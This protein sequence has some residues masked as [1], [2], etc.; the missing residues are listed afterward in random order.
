MRARLALLLLP[1]ALGALA[2]RQAVV[3]MGDA[4]AASL[5]PPRARHAWEHEEP[6]SLVLGPGG[7]DGASGSDGFFVR[8][9]EVAVVRP[10]SPESRGSLLSPAERGKEAA[11]DASAPAP[12]VATILVPAAAVA[13]AMQRR[14]VGAVNAVSPEGAP[15]GAS[16]RGVSRYRTGLRDGDVV[17]SVAGTPTPNVGAMVSAAMAAAQGGAPRISGQIMREGARMNVVL[18]LPK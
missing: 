1:F 12:P 7:P 18:E 16:L 15:V 3:P 9:P 11:G 13:R 14:D 10:P 17:V 6:R 4:V 5:A 8:F 2:L